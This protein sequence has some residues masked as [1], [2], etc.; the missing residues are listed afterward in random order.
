MKT[1]LITRPEPLAASLAKRLKDCGYQTILEPLLVLKPRV[2]AKPSVPDDVALVMT[3]RLAFSV[4]AAHRADIVPYLSKPCYCVG[5]RTGASAR[6]FGFTDVRTGEGDG[7]K[8]AHMILNQEKESRGLLH[9]GGED[10]S[11]EVLERLSSAGRS[12]I[13]WV[14]YKTDA[15]ESFSPAFVEAFRKKQID[16]ALFFS[17][18]TSEIFVNLATKDSLGSACFGM[19]V[20]GL[21]KA[22]TTPL[23]AF[24][25][26]RVLVAAQPTEDSLI[27]T[28][29][30]FLPVT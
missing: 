11:P 29:F 7:E 14:V 16:A 25:W 2:L 20:I 26:K 9:I 21:S 24:N 4:L 30:R 10:I 5:S 27:D 6:A 15:V 23:A 3:S 19:T 12:V 13:N 22:V 8:L 1:I 17:P 18:R 28:L